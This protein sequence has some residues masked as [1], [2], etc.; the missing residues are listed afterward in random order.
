MLVDTILYNKYLWDT[1]RVDGG[2][3]GCFVS[4]SFDNMISIVSYRD[5][6]IKKTI[7]TYKTIGN[8]I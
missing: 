7:N 1:I 4:T 5:P 6:N 2:A 3:Y 8:W